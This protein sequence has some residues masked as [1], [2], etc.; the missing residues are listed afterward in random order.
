VETADVGCVRRSARTVAGGRYRLW[1]A[2]PVGRPGRAIA[3][4]AGLEEFT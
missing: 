4:D 3:R 2:Y 1:Q